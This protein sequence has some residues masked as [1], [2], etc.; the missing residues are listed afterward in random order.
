MLQLGALLPVSLT[1]TPITF[2]QEWLTNLPVVHGEL[3]RC[4]ALEV[5]FGSLDGDVSEKTELR[6]G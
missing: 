2:W 4:L 5:A 1:T 6:L 3:I